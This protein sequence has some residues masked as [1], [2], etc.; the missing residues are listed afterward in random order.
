M[1]EVRRVGEHGYLYARMRM[2]QFHEALEAQIGTSEFAI[3]HLAGRLDFLSDRGTVSARSHLFA[4]IAVEPATLL[5]GYA[6]AFASSVGSSPVP[7][8]IKTFGQTYGLAEFATPE[9]AYKEAGSSGSR[10]EVDG[11]VHVLGP[12]GIEIVGP[13]YFYYTYRTGS[14]GSRHLVLFDQPTL[15][16]PNLDIATV[17]VKL[18]RLLCEVRDIGWALDGLA[19]LAGFGLHSERQGQMNRAARYRL[20]DGSQQIDVEAETDEVGR[21]TRVRVSGPHGPEPGQNGR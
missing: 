8:L 17:M 4:S 6:Q 10:E 16:V 9:L 2:E 20:T 7:G 21:V 13:T 14:A 1:D 18:P 11:L 12:A 3:D 19:R 15:E 5:W